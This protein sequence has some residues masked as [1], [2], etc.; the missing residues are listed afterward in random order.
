M[1]VAFRPTE[2]QQLALEK[3]S[4]FRIVDWLNDAL[5]HRRNTT[6]DS[7]RSHRRNRVDGLRALAIVA[8]A[9]CLAI[10]PPA[11]TPVTPELRELTLLPKDS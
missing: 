4:R 7:S 8:P 11:L 2:R 5:Q 1:L 6:T 3:L 9:L 10:G